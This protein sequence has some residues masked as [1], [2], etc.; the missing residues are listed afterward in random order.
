MF[1]ES[2]SSSFHPHLNGSSKFLGEIDFL[3]KGRFS[4]KSGF[5][6][7]LGFKQLS[8][9]SSNP[10]L[11]WP[12]LLEN[13]AFWVV[14]KVMNSCNNFLSQVMESFFRRRDLRSLAVA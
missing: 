9:F 10:I 2:D 3:K 7:F 12:K 5:L 6:Y 1:L 13:Y 4:G 8:H 11:A 14:A